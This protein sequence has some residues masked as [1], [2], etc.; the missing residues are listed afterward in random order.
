MRLYV[1]TLWACISLTCMLPLV[2]S[3]SKSSTPN[4]DCLGFAFAVNLEE[5][6]MVRTPKIRRGDNGEFPAQKNI[7]DFEEILD[8]DMEPPAAMLDNPAEFGG[9]K[10]MK[11]VLLRAVL[12]GNFPGNFPDW[13]DVHV[14]PET[15]EEKEFYSAGKT[16]RLLPIV[17]IFD[18]EDYAVNKKESKPKLTKWKTEEKYDIGIIL[19]NN[20]KAEELKL[21][22]ATILLPDLFKKKPSSD[23]QHR[24]FI[25]RSK[26]AELV[27]AESLK[28]AWLEQLE[29][30]ASHGGRFSRKNVADVVLIVCGPEPCKKYLGKGQSQTSAKRQSTGGELASRKIAGSGT[31]GTKEADEANSA[32]IK[33]PGV[34]EAPPKCLPADAAAAD[35]KD[36][37]SAE[38]RFTIL[39]QPPL[40][41]RKGDEGLL[42]P[43]ALKKY[44]GLTCFFLAIFPN[45]GKPEKACKSSEFGELQEQMR[46]ASFEVLPGNKIVITRNA[47]QPPADDGHLGVKG[48]IVHPPIGF[49]TGTC[50]IYAKFIG[51]D[52]VMR[53]LE[54]KISG[55]K[56]HFGLAMSGE[57]VVVVKVPFGIH[58]EAN[59]AKD[60]G[61]EHRTVT[62]DPAPI[63]PESGVV[64]IDL[65]GEQMARRHVVYIPRFNDASYKQ[66]EF[67]G[68]ESRKT[69][70]KAMV[71]AIRI[72]HLRLAATPRDTSWRLDSAAAVVFSKREK[73]VLMR[74][75]DL[76][77]LEST[78]VSDLFSTT[79]K[80]SSDNGLNS[81][82]INNFSMAG[83]VS[84][85]DKKDMFEAIK[86]LV[87]T[88]RR[89]DTDSGRP[90]MTLVLLGQ[91]KEY[92]DDRDNVCD[93]VALKDDLD[94]LKL[95]FRER[96]LAESVSI[97]S[98]PLVVMK[99]GAVGDL[100]DKVALTQYHSGN[101]EVLQ[102][103]VKCRNQTEDIAIY[104][105]IARNWF[106]VPATAA[107]FATAVGDQLGA[108]LDE[109]NTGS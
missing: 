93:T 1:A 4:F 10:N 90:S 69:I 37:L 104:P 94:W 39:V 73:D 85:Y 92:S 26:L 41:I 52:E 35:T 67:S 31:A 77:T 43:E 2:P 17:F 6:G 29:T 72:A 19:N 84:A 55:D 44:G 34:P 16:A 63:E 28:P 32:S 88:G 62:I 18:D 82:L 109:L 86:N 47:R 48:I 107:W 106:D 89:S 23:E 71:G 97:V 64:T 74:L 14:V 58:L 78:A 13:R 99:Q 83:W 38:H 75:D 12:R 101:P 96:E 42:P 66:G 53:R 65:R 33:C 103:V 9:S 51:A 3:T 15:R 56:K 27:R 79:P 22:D 60:C 20:K 105:L 24:V 59:S 61:T 7:L 5:P 25:Y 45:Y 108:V 98:F 54:L 68:K 50:A 57:D 102:G 87:A 40:F 70:G 95:R 11:C 81:K 36:D 8:D 80:R 91:M 46:S 100:A 76:S 21:D 49:A 30:I